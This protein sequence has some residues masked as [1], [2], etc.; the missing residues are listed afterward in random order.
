MEKKNFKFVALLLIFP[1]LQFLVF[2][3]YI[4]FSSFVLAFTDRFG[5]FDLKY[6]EIIFIH[7]E[8]YQYVL[9]NLQQISDMKQVEQ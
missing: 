6:M 4:N 8:T 3:V 9:V 2:Y 1:V 5:N 7:I